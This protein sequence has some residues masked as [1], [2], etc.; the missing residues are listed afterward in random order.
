MPEGASLL[1]RA[2]HDQE[3]GPGR[4]EDADRVGTGVACRVEFRRGARGDLG[5]QEGRAGADCCGYEHDP[6]PSPV[7]AARPRRPDS[8]AG[9]VRAQRTEQPPVGSGSGAGAPIDGRPSITPADFSAGAALRFSQASPD[10]V[11]RTEVVGP[12]AS[13][14][15]GAA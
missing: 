13:R 3:V 11:R 6:Q 5:Y 15:C 1:R 12:S 2:D 14:W 8:A 7:A 4:G 9:T 10:R